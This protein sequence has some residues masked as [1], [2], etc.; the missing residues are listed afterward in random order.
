[1]PFT[2]SDRDKIMG[3][4]GYAVT[5][6][7]VQYVQGI[8][9]TVDNQSADAVTRVQGI[10]TKLAAIDAEINTARNSPGGIYTQLLSEAQ[11]NVGAIAFTLG[12]EVKR[13]IY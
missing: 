9:T 13:N 5:A 1:M 4:L 2:T 3:F 8:L 7:N 11:R 6:E 10:L 12:I